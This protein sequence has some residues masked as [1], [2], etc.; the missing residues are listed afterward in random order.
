MKR[1]RRS[2]RPHRVFGWFLIALGVL[3]P[4]AML[5]VGMGLVIVSGAPLLGG[6]FCVGKVAESESIAGGERCCLMEGRWWCEGDGGIGWGIGLAV[7]N[8]ECSAWI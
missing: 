2:Q 8:Q 1:L 6:N 4:V 5:V 7:G 3:V